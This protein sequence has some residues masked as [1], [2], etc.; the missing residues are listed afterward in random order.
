MGALVFTAGAQNPE[1]PK[2]PWKPGAT[3]LDK[4]GST[5]LNPVAGATTITGTVKQRTAEGLL[6]QTRLK[7][8]GGLVWLTGHDAKEGT[9]ISLQAVK[10]GTFDYGA[11]SGAA[12]TVDA[13]RVVK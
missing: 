10:D 5:S 8:D 1:A 4:T 13:Y 2:Q 9:R 6:I 7:G 3:G 11:V 12:K